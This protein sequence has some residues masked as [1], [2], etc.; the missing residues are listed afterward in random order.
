MY[1]VLSAGT[2][3][4]RTA[5][6]A[7]VIKLWEQKIRRVMLSAPSCKCTLDRP[8]VLITTLDEM[9]AGLHVENTPVINHV[10]ASH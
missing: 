5:A 6:H 7:I 4:A 3:R 9:P 2:H 1:P 10:P 8:T